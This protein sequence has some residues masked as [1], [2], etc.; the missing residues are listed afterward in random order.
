MRLKHLPFAALIASTA[1]GWAFF[2]IRVVF[3]EPLLK[4]CPESAQCNQSK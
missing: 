3:I 2:G 1:L 4:N